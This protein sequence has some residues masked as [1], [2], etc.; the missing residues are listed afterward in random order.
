VRLS[1]L[2]IAELFFER[3]LSASGRGYVSVYGFC[4]EA[5][6]RRRWRNFRTDA[7]RASWC[8]PR[9][10]CCSWR[11]KNEMSRPPKFRKTAFGSMMFFL[12]S[13]GCRTASMFRRRFASPIRI[14]LLPLFRRHWS[15]GIGLRVG[16]ARTPRRLESSLP[17]TIAAGLCVSPLGYEHHVANGTGN[18]I[19]ANTVPLVDGFL[20]AHVAACYFH[21]V[22]P[23]PP[24]LVDAHR[25]PRP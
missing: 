20:L 6:R 8:R 4:R 17:A 11:L 15:R 5:I 24:E 23:T 2:A 22:Q 19:A 1:P 10:R 21:H 14:L 12:N 9:S 18:L 13:L 3:R 16:L 7:R 25:R